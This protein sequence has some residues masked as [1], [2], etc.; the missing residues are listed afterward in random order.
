[1]Q[2]ETQILEEVEA[3]RFVGA[4]VARKEDPRF[5]TGRGRYTDD[6]VVPGMLHAAFVRSP[7][8]R[9]SV[10]RVDSTEA[11]ALDGVAAVYTFDDLAEAADPDA[12]HAGPLGARPLAHD[13]VCF[14]GDPVALVVA[15]TRAIAE[16]ACE[17]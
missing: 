10:T 6:V 7:H 17:L 16:D 9:A 3:G 14:V 15:E 5:L 12:L 13:V 1:M 2:T 4:R 8:A 11:Q